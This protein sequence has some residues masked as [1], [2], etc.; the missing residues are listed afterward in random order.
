MNSGET[1]RKMGVFMP[2]QSWPN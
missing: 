2:C 1:P